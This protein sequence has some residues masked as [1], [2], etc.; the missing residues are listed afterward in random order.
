MEQNYLATDTD[1]Y[2]ATNIFSKYLQAKS[3]NEEKEIQVSFSVH[4]KIMEKN[5][6]F[7]IY[8]IIYIFLIS[9]LILIRFI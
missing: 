3:D 5:R 7:I 2:A 1:L 8:L 9:M 6:N 4:G